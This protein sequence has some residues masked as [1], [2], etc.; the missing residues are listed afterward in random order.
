M[1]NMVKVI[2]KND[3]D[4]LNALKN[5]KGSIGAVNIKRILEKKGVYLSEA[6]IGR[7]LSRFDS[8]GL[9]KKNGLNGR[10]LTDKGHKKLIEYEYFFKSKKYYNDILK[11]IDE[12]GSS[13]MI[14]YLDAREGIELQ[15]VELAIKNITDQELKELELILKEQMKVFYVYKR[16]KPTKSQGH[17]D[18]KFHRTII[19]FSRNP[20][21]E[22]F[23]DLL[24]C[25]EQIQEMYE[26]IAGQGYIAHHIEIFESI[27]NKDVNKAKRILKKHIDGVKQECIAYWKQ[28]EL[29]EAY[30][31]LKD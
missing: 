3:F 27:K 23:Y 13:G 18:Y 30:L 5:A 29:C 21:L 26:Y 12:M 6:T 19:K 25:S 4:V 22:A 31:D 24:R 2:D 17:L 15:A 7:I 20:Y 11:L 8:E 14:H 10:E 1:L 9:T 16:H 28:R